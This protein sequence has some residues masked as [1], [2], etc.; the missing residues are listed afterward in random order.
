MTTRLIDR[1]PAR[2]FLL[3][4]VLSIFVPQPAAQAQTG[5]PS[6]PK[7]AEIRIQHIGP[8]TINDDLIRGNIRA[9]V[10]DVYLPAAIIR[11]VKNLYGTGL[12]YNVRIT[13]TM[14]NNA[15]VLTYLVQENPRLT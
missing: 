2:W 8:S 12:I 15:V 11:D 7:I 10:G 9:K 1:K 4:L 13:D 5:E 6:G 14:T 3:A